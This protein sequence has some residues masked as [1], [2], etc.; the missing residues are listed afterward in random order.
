MSQ[1]ISFSQYLLA[2]DAQFA[3]RICSILNDEGYSKAGEPGID[4]AWRYIEDIAAQPG[5][6]ESYHAALLNQ[7]EQPG[8]ADDVITDGVLLS[9]I[10]TVM[11]S[12][13]ITL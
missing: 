12:A 8:A 2:S 5:L 1:T 11:N 3:G 6:A 4:M 13:G 9:A 7:V 10:V